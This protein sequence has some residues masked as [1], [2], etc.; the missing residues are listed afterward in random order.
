M[1]LKP[2]TNF[3]IQINIFVMCSFLA[4]GHTDVVPWYYVLMKINGARKLKFCWVKSKK[5][6][7]FLFFVKDNPFTLNQLI[8]TSISSP[9][10]R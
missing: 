10:P 8:S 6:L 5:G 7:V 1:F 4:K 9:P 2:R 3:L